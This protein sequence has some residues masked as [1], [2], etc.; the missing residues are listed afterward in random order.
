MVQGLHSRASRPRES[1]GIGG[2]SKVE[3]TFSSALR[4]VLNK[5]FRPSGIIL[6]FAPSGLRLCDSVQPVRNEANHAARHAQVTFERRALEPPLHMRKG[7]AQGREE[8]REVEPSVGLAL[9]RR[10][11]WDTLPYVSVSEPA[12]FQC[13]RC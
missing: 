13:S 7:S 8:S 2:N 6:T 4:G 10:N 3:K 12:G 9:W 5:R 11:L 1:N